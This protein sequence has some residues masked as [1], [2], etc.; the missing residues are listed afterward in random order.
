MPRDL[1]LTIAD[2][3]AR[4]RAR[5]ADAEA[6]SARPPGSVALLAVSKLHGADSVAAAHAAGQTAF[7][8]SYVQEA[9]DKQAALAHLPLDW[10]FIGRV[11]TNKT[12]DIASRF[13]WVHGLCEL[14][15]ARRLGE[16]R[17]AAQ[18]PLACCVQVNL[19]GEASKAGLAPEAVADF[20]AACRDIDGIAIRGLMTLPAPADEPAAQRRP[21]AALRALRDRLATPELPLATLSMGM[22]DDLEAAIAE[23]ATMVRVGTAIFGARP[24]AVRR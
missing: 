2:N 7:G 11:Q 9:L 16:Q 14:K 10:H 6:R 12:R 3:L 24:G 20:I 8:E 18:G 13:D 5:I 1:A 23:G 19:S 15:H 22:T 4:V 17:P 21:F